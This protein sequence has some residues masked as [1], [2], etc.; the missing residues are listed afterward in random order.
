MSE[1]KGVWAKPILCAK[2]KI[3][4]LAA[5]MLRGGFF[6]SMLMAGCHALYSPSDDVYDLTADN[7]QKMVLDS[8]FVWIVEFYA[9]WYVYSGT[10]RP[11]Y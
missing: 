9:P 6:L 10:W 2:R 4:S 1:E 5:A 7:F 11:L 3:F 8:H